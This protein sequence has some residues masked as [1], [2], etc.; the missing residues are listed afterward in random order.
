MCSPRCAPTSSTAAF[1]AL[2]PDALGNEFAATLLCKEEIVVALAP[3]H[4]LC[5][6]PRV[7]F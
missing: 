7:T 3:G 6:R 4:P 5:A 1:T 2:D